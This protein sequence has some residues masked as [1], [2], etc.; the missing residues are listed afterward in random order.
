M[1]RTENIFEAGR[2]GRGEDKATVQTIAFE[3]PNLQ[4]LGLNDIR[5]ENHLIPI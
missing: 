1:Q 5:D 4:I 2:G 3:E